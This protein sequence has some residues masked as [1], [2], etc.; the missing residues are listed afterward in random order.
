MNVINK[1]KDNESIYVDL[2]KLNLVFDIFLI[3][4][5]F[6]TGWVLLEKSSEFIIF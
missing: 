4:F 2:C 5:I 3:I 1:G 6:V